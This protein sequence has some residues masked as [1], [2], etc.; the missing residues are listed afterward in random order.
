MSKIPLPPGI[1]LKKKSGIFFTNIE[2]IKYL[3]KIANSIDFDDEFETSLEKKFYLELKK[4]TE[5]ILKRTKKG[6]EYLASLAKR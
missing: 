1:T 6:R 5:Q 2:D 3:N 4:S